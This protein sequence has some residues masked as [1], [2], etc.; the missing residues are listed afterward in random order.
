MLM[1]NNWYQC[2]SCVL[3]L[4]TFEIGS[5]RRTLWV[6]VFLRKLKK[7]GVACSF[8][9]AWTEKRE[10]ALFPSSKKDEE[11]WV[12][13]RQGTCFL[14]H[15]RRERKTVCT[16]EGGS[17]PLVRFPEDP[18]GSRTWYW[19]Q[20]SAEKYRISVDKLLCQSNSCRIEL[21]ILQSM[22]LLE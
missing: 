2:L 22:Y 18:T 7:F 14:C 15:C 17:L 1:L 16:E 6:L 4:T 8:C 20:F 3:R 13:L 21:N 5:R 10:G 9:F 19:F 12:K 11:M